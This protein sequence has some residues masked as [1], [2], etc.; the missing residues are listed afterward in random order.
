MIR[1]VHVGHG[2]ER[3]LS[4]F[5][6]QLAGIG[7]RACGRRKG[8]SICCGGWGI[9]VVVDI[10][11]GKSRSKVAILAQI[12]SRIAARSTGCHLGRASGVVEEGVGVENI[13]VGC[14]GRGV[15]VIGV[16]IRKSRSI[17]AILA[18]I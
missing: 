4:E 15:I 1:V 14:D 11:S 8:E 2:L 5:N 9:V 12:C 7:G 3:D 17:V 6:G 13:D 10:V 18:L 16:G